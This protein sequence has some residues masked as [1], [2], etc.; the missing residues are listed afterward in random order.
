M[1][2]LEM[3]VKRCRIEKGMLEYFY[4]SAV[5]RFSFLQKRDMFIIFGEIYLQV[6]RFRRNNIEE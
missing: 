3:I 4:D 6:K 5:D 1:T 2:S